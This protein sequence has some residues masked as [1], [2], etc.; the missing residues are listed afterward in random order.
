MMQNRRSLAS[1]ATTNS[2]TSFSSQRQRS[3]SSSAFSVHKLPFFWIIIQDPAN[4]SESNLKCVEDYIRRRASQLEGFH[5]KSFKIQFNDK[6]KN[7]Q[8]FVYFTTAEQTKQASE[9]FN[10]IRIDNCQL[11][12]FYREPV[13]EKNEISPARVRS[14]KII[15]NIF[16]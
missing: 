15:Q 16:K 8:F 13:K 5:A 2:A 6:Y 10:N 7:H 14:Y 11:K 1:S 12:C 4:P 9:L 3:A